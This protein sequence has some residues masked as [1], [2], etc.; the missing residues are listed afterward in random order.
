VPTEVKAEEPGFREK[1]AKVAAE[2]AG[3]APDLLDISH[4][5]GQIT[6]RGVVLW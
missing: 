6:R 2:G 3:W 4:T 5:L 1:L